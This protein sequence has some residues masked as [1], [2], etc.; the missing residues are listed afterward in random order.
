MTCTILKQ[1]NI[2]FF[3]YC[4]CHA[5]VGKEPLAAD[6]MNQV[7]SNIPAKWRSFA[8]QLYL[9]DADI[10]AI[11]SNYTKCLDRFHEVFKIWK[12]QLTRSPVT[13]DTVLC[14][15]RSNELKEVNLAGDLEQWL[16][17]KSTTANY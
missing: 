2:H 1:V 14:V 12:T 11:E 6:F 9:S 15:L 5:Y 7:A 8:T 13:W 17:G 16:T 10:E 4:F 3:Q